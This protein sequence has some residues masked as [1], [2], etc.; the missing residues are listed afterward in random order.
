MSLEY[1]RDTYSVPA[2][3]GRRVICSGKPGVIVNAKNAHIM[4]LIDGDDK[5]APYHPTWQVQYGE[6]AGAEQAAI[7]V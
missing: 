5:P 6:M 4:V 3:V 7:T 2:N 1:I